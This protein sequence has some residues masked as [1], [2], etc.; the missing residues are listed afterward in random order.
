MRYENVRIL[1]LT[2]SFGS[3]KSTVS[4]EFKK[5]GAVVFDSDA[6]V[7][8]LLNRGDIKKRINKTFGISNRKE[9]A[10][11]VFKNAARRKKLERILH[12]LVER[13]MGKCI[14]NSGKKRVICDIPLLFEA[15]WQKKFDRT[16]FVD[17][18]LSLRIAR[19]R[20]R[21][22]SRSEVLARSKAQ[23]PAR[24]KKKM[25]D[26]VLLNNGSLAQLKKKI[27]DLTF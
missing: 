11:I 25:A 4:L 7:H 15:G 14:A 26:I 1:G 27:N 23:W 9:L 17:A 8:S 10:T 6:T 13:A 3:G 20:K 2:G 18:P 5:R 24:R 22:F 19:L 16:I 21:G 12:P